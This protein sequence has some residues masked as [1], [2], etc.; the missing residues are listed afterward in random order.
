MEPNSMAEWQAINALCLAKQ[1]KKE[2]A[3]TQIRQ[4]RV[5]GPYSDIIEFEDGGVMFALYNTPEL[6][7]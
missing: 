7:Y 1:G 6:Q 5:E 3:E 2:L 4:H